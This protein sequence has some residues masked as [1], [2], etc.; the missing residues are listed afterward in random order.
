METRARRLAACQIQNW[1]R[2][3]LCHTDPVTLGPVRASRIWAGG[4]LFN[5]PELRDFVQY[6]GDTRH[7]IT[8]QR[9]TARVLERLGVQAVAQARSTHT[10]RQQNEGLREYLETETNGHVEAIIC[11]IMSTDTVG[12]V[13][14]RFVQERLPA[15]AASLTDLRRVRSTNIREVLQRAIQLLHTQDV[16]PER[17]ALFFLAHS[18]F[19]DYF[20]SL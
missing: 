12:S 13:I 19:R 1:W 7:P 14:L 5:L 17:F 8:R 18:F 3:F 10:E 11:D 6:T 20:M 15:L 9:F 4:T 2:G 16:A